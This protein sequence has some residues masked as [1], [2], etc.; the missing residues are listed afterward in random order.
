MVIVVVLLMMA[1]ISFFNILQDFETRQQAM[2]SQME[3]I[4]RAIAS[5]GTL[6]ESQNW[7]TYQ[8]YIDNIYL[9][10]D[11]IVYVAIKDQNDSLTAYILNEDLV[12]FPP[13]VAV[14]DSVIKEA[15]LD[16][17]EEIISPISEKDLGIVRAPIRIFDEASGTVRMGYSKIELNA[18]LTR[19]RNRNIIMGVIFVIVGMIASMFLSG[20]LTK[21][22]MRLSMAM[23]TVPYG[24]QDTIVEIKSHDEI[25]ILASSFNFM[26]RS[27]REREFFDQYEKELSQV[28]TLDRIISV[29]FNRLHYLYQ[30]NRGALFIKQKDGKF[31]LQYRHNFSF[32][33]DSKFHED[34]LH[35]L[36]NHL[37]KDDICFSLDGLRIIAHEIPSMRPAIPVLEENR[38]HWVAALLR[39]GSCIGVLYLGKESR[40]FT[41]DLEEKKYIVNLVRH[42]LLPVENALLY[43]D[44]TENERL[45]KELEIAHTVQMKLLP[46]QKPDVEGFDIFGVCLPAKE[47][48]G[49]Y[50]DYVDID[51]NHIGVVIADVS[52]KGTSASFYMAEIKGMIIS[53]STLYDSPDKLLKSLNKQLYINSE[54][55]IFATMVYGILNKKNGDFLFARAGHNPVLYKIPEK[56]EVKVITPNGL[57]LGLD[58]G[59]IFDRVICEDKVR[60]KKGETVL[61]YTDGVS[62]AMNEYRDEFGED[63]LKD[64][65]M[66]QNG[67]T[68]EMSC[69]HILKEVN[70]YTKGIEQSD[71]MTLVMIKSEK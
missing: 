64:I 56:S 59:E 65:L 9:A 25:G 46:Q 48:G 24:T 5:V 28:F 13:G 23:E 53:L 49:D 16:L 3:S 20:K 51:K 62:E 17:D 54:R 35:A 42:T 37:Q 18:E 34:L 33:S 71:D 68:A 61:L 45:K 36:E 44:L 2:E 63:R 47:V 7:D 19:I 15:V 38:I 21:P 70:A 27:L 40:D 30:I 57:G 22:L 31:L 32:D 8:D 10:I 4:A 50:F 14:N 12:E 58:S 26:V 60:L 67:F 41:V 43:A 1:V 29:L 52:G 55:Q 39:K 6:D 11:D 66:N 69:K